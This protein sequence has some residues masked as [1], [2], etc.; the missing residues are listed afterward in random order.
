MLTD[1][2]RDEVRA[3]LAAL[4]AE[5]G[6][7]ANIKCDDKYRMAYPDA[8]DLHEWRMEWNR[9]RH[10]EE[11]SGVSPQPSEA[12][13]PAPAEAATDVRTVHPARRVKKPAE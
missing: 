5:H 8:V 10:K 11:R 7:L 4:Q 12:E 9:A 2:A 6:S 3:K 13:S 1:K